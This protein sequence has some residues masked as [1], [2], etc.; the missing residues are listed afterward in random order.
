MRSRITYII[1]TSGAHTVLGW[2]TRRRTSCPIDADVPGT[3]VPLGLSN[4]LAGVRGAVVIHL[5]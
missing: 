2:L 5:E 1:F 3:H 4:S